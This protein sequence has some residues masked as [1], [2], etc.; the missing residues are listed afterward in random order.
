VAYAGHSITTTKLFLKLPIMRY[1]RNRA[2]MLLIFW[3]FSN[4]VSL[5]LYKDE[6]E[7]DK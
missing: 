3:L 5:V 6:L 7:E 1:N 2:E 4:P